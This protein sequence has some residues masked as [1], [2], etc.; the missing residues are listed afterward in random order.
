MDW[1]VPGGD[2]DINSLLRKMYGDEK[3]KAIIKM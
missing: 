2:Y 1:V 3:A